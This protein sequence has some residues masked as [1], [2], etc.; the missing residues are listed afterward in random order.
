MSKLLLV[1]VAGLLVTGCSWGKQGDGQDP[2]AVDETS[3]SEVVDE[4]DLV[5]EDY[6]QAKEVVTSYVKLAK[7]AAVEPDKAASGTGYLTRKALDSATNGVD[8]VGKLI[9]LANVD[10]LSNWTYKV[11]ESRFSDGLMKVWVYYVHDEGE[12][13]WVYGLVK[14]NGVWKIDSIRQ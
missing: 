4:G 9:Q 6:V 1:L 3:M 11:G 8:E 10:T 7:L 5:E 14:Q 2:K 13:T 12:D